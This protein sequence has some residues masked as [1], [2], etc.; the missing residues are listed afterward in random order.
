[1]KICFVDPEGI[2]FGLNAGI[3]YIASYLKNFCGYDSIKVFDFNNKSNNIALRIDEIRN[4]DV[5]G[6]SIQS[7]TCQSALKIAYRVKTKNN[8]LI[9]GGPH[10]T[11]DGD[12][13]IKTNKI[14]DFGIFG[15]GEKTIAALLQA[16]E[17]KANFELIK[18]I[19]YRSN[20]EIIFTGIPNRILDLD[21]LPYP[22]YSVFDSI[23]NGNIYNYPLVTSRGCPYKCIYCCVGNTIGNKWVTRSVVN[24]MSELQNAK[25]TYHIGSFNIQDDNFSLDIKRAKYLCDELINQNFRIKWSC[26]NGIRADKIDYELMAKM[27]K[28]GCFG[29][30]IGIESAVKKE[31]AFIKKGED[32]SLILKAIE[33]A[34]YNKIWVTGNFI[35][36]LPYSNLESIRT[37]IKFATRLKL[38]GC[39]FNLLVPFP[40]TEIW[41]WVHSHGRILNDWRKGFTIGK[42]PLIIFETDEFPEKDRIKAYYESN[43]E[44]M[45]YFAFMNEHD[46]L[47]VIFFNVIKVIL[48]HDFFHLHLHVFWCILNFKRIIRKISEKNYCI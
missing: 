43:T 42:H 36:G 21:S 20:N 4:F 5:I 16:L 32:F 48:R 1:M 27:K 9:A 13:F 2:H 46:S 11:L 41:N 47:A 10:I 40:K 24:I 8:I 22:D 31:F 7:H 38:E 39:I 19:F 33:I 17:A 28:A 18:G 37:S 34:H 15:E 45:N 23:K 12:S 35:I 14:F 25:N 30:S 3:G 26:F 44:C 6:F 29:I